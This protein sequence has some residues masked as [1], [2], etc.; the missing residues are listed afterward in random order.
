MAKAEARRPLASLRG[1]RHV[2]RPSLAVRIGLL[3]LGV[4]VPCLLLEGKL[5]GSL[6]VAGW[7]EW[8]LLVVPI[9]GA[10]LGVAAGLQRTRLEVSD[11]GL[12][13]R[14]AIT[15]ERAVKWSEV[16][17]VHFAQISSRI[18]IEDSRGMR[19]PVSLALRASAGFLSILRHHVPES[20]CGPALAGALQHLGLSE[21][22][23]E[24]IDEMGSDDRTSNL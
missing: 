6:E 21:D 24:R 23:H 5:S 12:V 16:R 9:A 11:Q 17:T 19:L 22:D 2:L 10:L 8:L 7:G 1:D 3:V 20:I 4:F 13:W 15:R 18:I 14:G